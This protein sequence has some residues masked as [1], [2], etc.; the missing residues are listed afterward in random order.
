MRISQV[1]RKLSQHQPVLITA[2]SLCDPA[3]F[4][5]TSLM[6]F[7]GIWLDLEHHAHSDETAAALMRS[8][9]V[10]TAD[11]MVRVAK[12]EFMR[13]GRILESG[14]QG[15]MYPRCESAEEAAELVKWSKFAPAGCRGFDGGNGDMPYCSMKVG[16]YVQQANRE[17]F[18]VAQLEDSR[19]IEQADAIAGVDGIDVLFFGPGDF[20]VLSGIP[21][22]FD[23][24]KIWAAIDR[25]A[26][27][28]KNAGKHWGMP[29]PNIDHASRL[30]ALGARF[31]CHGTDIVAVKL[32]LESAQRSFQTIGFTFANRL[33]G[34]SGSAH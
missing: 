2:L 32:S 24:P 28:A 22:Q 12:G 11:V 20:A 6:G 27:A 10:G 31:I 14:A 29:S 18:I 5:M 17:T 13:I 25:V 9:R 30:M 21:G 19:S 16:E 33:Q 26:R 15:I 1:K 8:A 4:E 34:T 3:L 23:H 7:D